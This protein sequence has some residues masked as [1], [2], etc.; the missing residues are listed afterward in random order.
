MR[1]SM[2]EVVEALKGIQEY[3]DEEIGKMLPPTPDRDNVELLKS[4]KEP[5]SPKSVIGRWVSSSNTTIS[6]E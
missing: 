3:K 5:P 6:G 4:S 1:P 2:N